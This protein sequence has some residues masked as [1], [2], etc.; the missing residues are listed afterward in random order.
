MDATSGKDVHDAD[1]PGLLAVDEHA[2]AV[3][4]DGF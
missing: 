1:E 4:H 2:V 3:E